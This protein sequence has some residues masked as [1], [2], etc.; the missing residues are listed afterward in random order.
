MPVPPPP[1]PPPPN[2]DQYG[3]P[4][5]PEDFAEYGP[6]TLLGK[7]LAFM[8]PDEWAVAGMLALW[9]IVEVCRCSYFH[10]C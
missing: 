1:P 3:R 2:T 5:E 4:W 10:G 8:G 9:S 6:A 7:L